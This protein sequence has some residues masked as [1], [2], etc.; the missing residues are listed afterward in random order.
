VFVRADGSKITFPKSLEPT[1]ADPKS[2]YRR[3][4]LE[5]V[6]NSDPDLLGEEILKLPG[7][8]QFAEV[9]ACFPPIATMHVY[10]SVGTRASF[11]KV[12]IFYGGSTRNFDPAA[13]IPA[14]ERI[15]KEGGVLDGLVGGWLPVVRF[16]YP[17]KAGT[18]SELLVYAPVRI[19]N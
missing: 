6:F 13:Y 8:P 9:A 1:W 7:D 16:V 19:E 14:I 18:W 2:L 12:G 11:E 5:E 17:E 10:S 3:H 4:T 15:R